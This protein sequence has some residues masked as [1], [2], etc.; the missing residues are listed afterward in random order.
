MGYTLQALIGEFA[1]LEQA[2]LPDATIIALPQGKALIPLSTAFRV[3]HDISFLPLTDE[4]VDVFPKS[5]ESLI[6]RIAKIAYLE[7]EF[8]GGEGVQAAAI[9]NYGKLIF[10]PLVA[11]DAIN[12]ALSLLGVSNEDHIDEFEA[13]KLGSRRNTDDWIE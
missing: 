7:A 1:S 10:G 9:W 8:F 6:H 12:R 4:G 3:K 5:I 13:L 11:P 2:G